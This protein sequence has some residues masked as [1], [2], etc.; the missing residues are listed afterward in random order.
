MKTIFF[1]KDAET[2][3]SETIR[4]SKLNSCFTEM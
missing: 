2:D 4:V 1:E 3:F